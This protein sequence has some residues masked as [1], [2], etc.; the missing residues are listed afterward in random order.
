MFKKSHVQ[1]QHLLKL[2]ERLGGKW[3]TNSIVQIQHL[4]KLN[5]NEG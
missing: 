2:N 3:F 5:E 1:I 4:L